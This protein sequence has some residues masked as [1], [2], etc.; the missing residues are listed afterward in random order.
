MTSESAFLA[1][2]SLPVTLE[3]AEAMAAPPAKKARVEEP[4]AYGEVDVETA[5]LKI[6]EGKGE[7]YMIPLFDNEVAYIV[8]TPSAPTK[9]AYGFDMRG[10][11]EQ[12][13]FN[14]PGTKAAG[15]ESL[16]IQIELDNE[17]VKFFE[18]VDAKFKTLFP[19]EEKYEWTSLLR[20]TKHNETAAKVNVC[21]SGEESALT[22]VKFIRDGKVE[23]GK[24]WD[25]FKVQ[26]DAEKAGAYAFGGGEL[27]VTVKLR[28]WSMTGKDGV[29]R[30]GLSLAATHVMIKPRE[31]VVIEVAD[32]LEAW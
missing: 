22:L 20:T 13:S 30:K 4:K 3:S 2:A 27:K 32:V 31:R 15:N 18:M 25:Y 21:L 29:I 11:Y 17:Q 5:S 8:L 10:Q 26:A 23:S 16:A 14:S 9:I 19:T 12:R 28:A 7:K 24:G 1:Q 6:V